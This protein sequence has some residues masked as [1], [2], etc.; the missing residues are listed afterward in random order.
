MIYRTVLCIFKEGVCKS[1]EGDNLIQ[2][3]FELENIS[4]LE[5]ALDSLHKDI[6]ND[7][8]S[9][10]LF[11]IYTNGIDKS[12]IDIVK[13]EILDA[14][15]TASIGEQVQMEAFAMAI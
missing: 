1:N 15:P 5:N 9:S 10:I 4:H 11:H 3:N 14:F 12:E 2:Y 13:S 8:Y 7:S 6:D